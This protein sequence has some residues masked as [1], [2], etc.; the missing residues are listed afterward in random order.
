MSTVD[1]G[2]EELDWQDE[3]TRR[4]TP[5]AISSCPP[6]SGS[7]AALVVLDRDHPGFRDPAY[8][9]RRD[10]IAALALGHLPGAPIPSVAYTREEL[11]VWRT[12]LESLEALHTRHACEE[13]LAC[14]GALGFTPDRIPQLGEVSAVLQCITGFSLSPVAGLVTPRA[15]MTR[16]ADQTFL[17]TQ[18]V[19]HSSTPLYTPEPDV[20]HELVGHAALL[21]HPDFARVNRRFGDATL[22]ADER[23]VHALIRAYWYALE[24][25]VVGPPSKL[26]VVGAGLLSSFGELGRFAQ[27]PELQ[28]FDLDRIA[29]TPFDPTSYQTVLFVATD[30]RTLLRQLERWLDSIIANAAA[31]LRR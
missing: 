6:A 8:R 17:A 31:K 2:C 14:R 10:E 12:A 3:I 19:R 26:R 5:S 21:A 25:G 28:P 27:G 29:D 11:E 23:T 24:F 20:I 4:D 30:T 13:Y 22:V 18:Y 16:L 15:F 1:D 9:R 7:A